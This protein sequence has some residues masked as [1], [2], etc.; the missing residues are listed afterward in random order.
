[1]WPEPRPL[2]DDLPAYEA[3]EDPPET[4]AR[5]REIAREPD[6]PL[7]LRQALALALLR[8]PALG[9]ASW[10]VRIREARILQ[11]GLLPNPKLNI[12][13]EE[14]GGRDERS[15]F[16]AAETTL[17]LSQL[18]ELGGKQSARRRVAEL[19]RDAAAWTYETRRLAVLADTT[20]AFL[21]L[22]SA[23]ERLR[24]AKDTDRLSEQVHAT[25]AERV[26]AGKV[27]P[28]EGTKASITLSHS[29]I[30]REK[31]LR[32]V[33]AA[34]ARLAAAWNSTEPRFEKAAGAMTAP[35][36]IP[37]LSRL[38]RFVSR[39]PEVARWT[40][41]M[42]RRLAALE[43][44]RSRGYP[45]LTASGGVQR[46][47]ESDDYAFVFGVSLPLPLF[48]RNQGDIRGTRY[49]LAQAETD[50]RAAEMAAHT[51]LTDTYAAL[52]SAHAEVLALERDVLPAAER[53][54]EAARTGYR[55][56]KFGYLDV[57]DAQRTLFE[58][59]AR[60]IK[61]LTAYHK[62]LAVIESLL[63]STL[64]D[65]DGEHEKEERP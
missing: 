35:D 42:E 65:L 36:S 63:G 13:V 55:Q 30:E 56:G 31:A 28:L 12:E 18:I 19:D 23:Q 52:A 24:L 26:K 62:A 46:F 41:E 39:N 3:P 5:D 49:R 17:R 53:A 32:H 43:L 29:R 8:N 38:R 9:S 44:A 51:T 59:R 20:L 22:L 45:D 1:M 2:G 14:I 64:D 57:L 47:E 4:A 15:G 58:S 54:F 16:D 10:E 60:R 33:S 40:M 37:P 11:A 61:A 48:D 7:P 27:S 34:R 6:G 25:V 21:D 50:R